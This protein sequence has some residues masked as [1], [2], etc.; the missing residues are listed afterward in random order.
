MGTTFLDIIQ[1]PEIRKGKAKRRIMRLTQAEEN[2]A[3][4]TAHTRAEV[5][6]LAGIPAGDKAHAWIYKQI[7]VGKLTE[8][9]LRVKPGEPPE[10]E[11]HWYPDGKSTPND[12]KDVQPKS[13]AA[14]EKNT[15][16]QKEEPD[17]IPTLDLDDEEM[18][19]LM[20]TPEPKNT[21]VDVPLSQELLDKGFS[22]TLNINFTFNK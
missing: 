8:T 4:A 5:A 12:Q 6:K 14:K 7:K 10:Y 3:L 9:L 13:L 21:Q 19:A 16:K 15:P 20:N 22:I 2:G 17:E 1:E 18:E 11:Y